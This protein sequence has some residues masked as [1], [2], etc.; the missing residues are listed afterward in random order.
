MFPETSQVR[1]SAGSLECLRCQAPFPDQGLYQHLLHGLHCLLCPLVFYSLRQL[2]S[3]CDEAHSLALP[4]NRERLR[5]GYGLAATDDGRLVARTPALA[6]KVPK[7]M[8]GCKELH[9][10][11]VPKGKDLEVGAGVGGCSVQN[12]SIDRSIGRSGE[13]NK[14]PVN[15]MHTLIL[16]KP[17]RYFCI[18]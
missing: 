12:Q 10:A 17:Y 1:G 9:L 8:L 4:I 18:H 2:R 6:A 3:H 7:D 11:L 14:D 15:S 5:R 16:N 13:I